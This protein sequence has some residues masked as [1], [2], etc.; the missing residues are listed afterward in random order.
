MTFLR[1][2]ILY[3]LF[4][5]ALPVIIHFFE[6]RI[7]K[8]TNFTNLLFL[9]S[10]QKEQHRYKKLKKWIILLLRIS[11]F[12]ALILAFALPVILSS[13]KD[14]KA[15]PTY[16][17]YLD[18]SFS[19]SAKNSTG[20]TLL[21][22]AKE[23]LYQWSKTLPSDAKISWFS[24]ENQSE[25]QSIESFQKDILTL[26][27]GEKQL[28]SQEVIL[29]AKQMFNSSKAEDAF[30]IWYTDLQNWSTLPDDLDLSII[31]RPLKAMSRENI[32]LLSFD[33]EQTNPE[34]T[35]LNLKIGNTLDS[36]K[37]PSVKLYKND[38]LIAQTGT[39]LLPS[40]DKELRFDL[41][42]E[43]NS[44]GKITIEDSGLAFDDTLYFNISKPIKINILSLGRSSKKM[45]DL[46]FADRDFEFVQ[47]EPE[48]LDY[49][50]INGMNLIILD[51]LNSLDTPLLEA[52]DQHINQGGGVIFI[53]DV[54]SPKVADSFLS[55]FKFGRTIE[56][57]R[58]AQKI[59]DI[60]YEDPL[61]KSVLAKN[62]NEF[63]YPTIGES[64]RIESPI[65][66]SLSL[67]NG[68]PFLLGRNQV[69]LFTGELSGETTNFD[70]SPLSVAILIQ[71]ARNTRPAIQ[72]YYPTQASGNR[73][74]SSARL[75]IILDSEDVIILNRNQSQIIPRQYQF[76]DHCE[77]NFQGNYYQA[78]HYS[79]EVNEKILSWFSFNY[80]RSESQG[81]F[82]ELKKLTSQIQI[83]DNLKITLNNIDATFKPR[84]LWPLFIIFAL[85]CFLT[86]M[87]LLKK[88][89]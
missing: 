36:E 25:S 57:N 58:N 33:L 10:I 41:G 7:F 64:F 76:I 62:V 47:I 72:P 89:T 30:L 14:G 67:D 74:T 83:S 56:I 31:M 68:D 4:L 60:S 9:D 51:G 66:A 79:A 28:S 59:V 77:L 12:T 34:K 86:E 53:P 81:V 24:N 70:Q 19:A 27:A 18:N 8:S 87:L 32:S 13:K 69:F 15:H 35:I 52:L 48:T 73:V 6:F 49:S 44:K 37:S 20:I 17:I 78:G 2:E 21:S 54:N 22:E 75:P 3:A 65:E 11:Y 39:K 71:I 61:L 38:S 80:S 16:V 82:H 29:T 23:E 26:K 45:L 43:F 63:Q 50:I 1:P 46:V 85:I 84:H 40:Q 55:R 88:N 42:S 5:L